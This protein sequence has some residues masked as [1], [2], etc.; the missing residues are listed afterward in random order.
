MRDFSLKGKLGARQPLGLFSKEKLPK[1][2]S[3]PLFL[4]SCCYIGYTPLAPGTVGSLF[5]VVIFLLIRA[6]L[7]A[8]ILATTCLITLG[9]LV[10]GRVEESLGQ[11]D[12]KPVVIDDMT[13][14]LV[15]FFLMP[16]KTPHLVFAFLLYRLIDIVKPYPIRKI[17]K[18]PG[19]LGIMLDDLL[20]ALCANLLTHIA[21]GLL[22]HF[23]G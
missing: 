11:K 13:G 21:F 14:V 9:F 18:L 19:S 12:P 22:P 5:G 6:N 3:L 15:A 1:G 8:Y 23:A 20:G 7:I 10:S 2:R 4:A 17:E 16:F